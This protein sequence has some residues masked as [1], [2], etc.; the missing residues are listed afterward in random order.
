MSKQRRKHH[1]VVAR[2]YT[3][4]VARELADNFL[5]KHKPRWR[6]TCKAANKSAR[7]LDYAMIGPEFY[8]VAKQRWR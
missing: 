7:Q 8:G 2:Q 4:K 6:Q 1:N 3:Y 5:Y